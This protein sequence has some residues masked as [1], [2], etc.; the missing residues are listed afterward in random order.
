APQFEGMLLPA[1]LRSVDAAV[2]RTV[3]TPVLEGSVVSDRHLAPRTRT[4]V[5]GAVPPGMRAIQV[6]ADDVLVPEPGSVVDVLVTFDP[7]LVPPGEEATVTAVR[8]ALVLGSSGEAGLDG[9]TS[10]VGVTLLTDEEGARRLAYATANGIV[11]LALA[12]PEDSCCTTSSKPSSSE[13]SR[14]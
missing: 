14:G 4:G 6:V 12:P 3:A 5:D 9:A 11:T 7:G 1:A 10:R 13:S 2:G 8:G